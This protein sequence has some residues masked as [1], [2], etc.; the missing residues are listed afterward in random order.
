MAVAASFVLLDL[1]HIPI[2]AISVMSAAALPVVAARLHRRGPP[3]DMI[4][5]LP[6]SR[7]LVAVVIVLGMGVAYMG[8][9]L[10]WYTNDGV[11]YYFG[12][13][14]LIAAEGRLPAEAIALLGQGVYP[15]MLPSLH[16]LAQIL[17][18]GHAEVV[19]AAFYVALLTIV[20]AAGHASRGTASLAVTVMLGTT[21]LLFLSGSAVL[22]NLPA[23]AFL[24]AGIVLL[25]S[26][27]DGREANA[28]VPAGFLLAAAAL[29]RSELLIYAS[30]PLLLLGVAALSRNEQ[31]AVL[32]V[33]VGYFAGLAPWIIWRVGHH[34]ALSAQLQLEW[35]F[36][37]ESG[38]LAP[39][40]IPI[41]DLVVYAMQLAAIG[42]VLYFWRPLSAATVRLRMR[43]SLA[44]AA[45][46]ILVIVTWS[47]V[48]A[49]WI[50]TTQSGVFGWVVP[51]ITSLLAI[52]M[53]WLRPGL[54]SVGR[55]VLG[56]LA[57]KVALRL[58]AAEGGLT[59]LSTAPW[60]S[61]NR[62]FLFVLPLAAVWAARTSALDR[63]IARWRIGVAAI[64][65]LA[66]CDSLV[67]LAKDN[68]VR[69]IA[70]GMHATSTSEAIAYGMGG[71]AGKLMAL[72]ARL[73]AEAVV[74]LPIGHV[75]DV[76]GN[77]GPQHVRVLVRPHPVAE[78]QYDF[79]ADP[80]GQIRFETT[81]G[82]PCNAYRLYG[83]PRDWRLI[84]DCGP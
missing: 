67:T 20:A 56:L 63:A 42:L 5:A 59:M 40:L 64:F 46:S 37:S 30:V 62:D 18:V 2:T 53:A 34:E 65:A 16:A 17:G 11:A 32:R 39:Q 12:K 29:T 78:I 77:L 8:W 14:A 68:R 58:L 80:G 27:I 22:T 50:T 28:L 35:G 23:A 51:I 84:R 71:S 3:D 44:V 38:A 33:G 54:E 66:V 73:P 47:A 31:T 6:L 7:R 69:L 4:V 26:Y 15:L 43:A 49:T 75:A 74:H 79:R 19:Y 57:I 70:R 41:A 25:L 36:G 10:P 13:G 72:A 81:T 21:P 1:L 82:V 76:L 55:M 45:V 52:E 61:L 24:T 60:G 83:T 9:R 48:H